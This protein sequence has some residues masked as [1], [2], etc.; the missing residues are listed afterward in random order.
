M[1]CSYGINETLTDPNSQ[2]GDE[3]TTSLAIDN[4]TMTIIVGHCGRDVLK[5][6]QGIRPAISELLVSDES[7]WPTGHVPAYDI[8]AKARLGRAG[9]LMASGDVKVMTYTQASLKD[10]NGGL[11]LFHR[12]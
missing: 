11:V 7:K 12:Y 9:F 3:I 1:A 8:E 6:G 2:G 5:P 4:P 10:K